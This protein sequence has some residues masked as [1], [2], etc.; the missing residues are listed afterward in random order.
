MPQFQNT[1]ENGRVFV[2]R[3]AT[4]ELIATIKTG[5]PKGVQSA[6]LNPDGTRLYV[7]N[8]GKKYVQIY[9]TL[10]YALLSTFAADGFPGLLGSIF[11]LTSAGT[12]CAVSRAA[13]DAANSK[14]GAVT[15]SVAA[16]EAQLQQLC[17]DPD[18]DI[19]GATPEEQ[20]SILINGILAM[21]KG[22]KMQLYK[23]LG[24]KPEKVVNL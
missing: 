4:N 10:N 20:I 22:S 11:A 12:D 5:I 9:D 15:A 3:A 21:N 19:A 18:F 6:S 13:L 14:L 7:I 17:G 2:F 23:A 24:G 1:D 8:L 16:T